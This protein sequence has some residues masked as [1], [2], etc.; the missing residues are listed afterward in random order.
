MALKKFIK[1]IKYATGTM[2]NKNFILF[3]QKRRSKNFK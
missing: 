1:N 3:G 2:T